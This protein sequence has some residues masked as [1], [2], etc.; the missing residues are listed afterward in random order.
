MADPKHNSPAHSVAIIGFAGRFPGARD[1]DEF[2][3]NVRDGVET[4]VSFSDAQLEA[5]RV[6]VGLRSNPAYVKRGTVL[7]GADLFD[8]AFFGFSPREAQIIDPQQ[9]IFLE[10]AWE[11]LEHSGYAAPSDRYAVGVYAGQGINTYLGRHI[12][13]DPA[14]MAAVG[15]YQ[16]M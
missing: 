2:W 6:D 9:R 14:L 12:A 3:Q 8:A 5:A 13:S 7:D 15:G 11:A 1:L 10:C 4:L 16:L